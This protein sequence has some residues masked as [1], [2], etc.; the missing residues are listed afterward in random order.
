METYN[1]DKAAKVWQRVQAG[2]A[3]P[4][5]PDVASLLGLIANEWADAA[6]YLQLS[7]KLQGKDAAMLRRLFDEEQAHAA[8]LKGIY[9]LLTGERPVIPSPKAPNEPVEATLR[10]CYGREMRC[11]AEYEQRSASREYGPVF[12]QL[13]SQEWEHCKIVLQLL[14]NLKNAP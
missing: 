4:A 10:R 3:N 2:S 11:L 13:A 9:T 6:T 8:C 5:M 12:S 14:G 1:P 7:R